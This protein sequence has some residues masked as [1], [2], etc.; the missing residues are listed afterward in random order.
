MSRD[1]KKRLDHLKQDQ[2][3]LVIKIFSKRKKVFKERKKFEKIHAKRSDFLQGM[4]MED[5]YHPSLIGRGGPIAST[6]IQGTDFVF[7]N[8]MVQ[9]LRKIVNFIDLKDKIMVAAGEN[10]MRKTPQQAY[11]LIDNMTQHHYQWD[12][13]VQYDTTTDMSAH[14]SKTTFASS[15]Q[16]DTGYTIQ[17][18][19]HQPGPG[20]PNTFHY[21]YSD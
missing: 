15:E 20:H 10:I 4:T 8:H 16:V 7:N 18:V 19:Q 9:M 6:T 2:E 14:Y 11:D 5:F 1:E 17:S 21:T 13:K 12:S 3:M